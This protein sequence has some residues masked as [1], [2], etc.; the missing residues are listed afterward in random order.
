MNA[1]VQA[2]LQMAVLFSRSPVLSRAST[3]APPPLVSNV[4]Q[5]CNAENEGEQGGGS[6]A[7]GRMR[8][9]CRASDVFPRTAAAA[10]PLD[11]CSGA[12]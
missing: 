7:D 12:A 8:D 9:A 11:V 4:T 5:T 10:A 3:P 2:R 1:Y 6:G